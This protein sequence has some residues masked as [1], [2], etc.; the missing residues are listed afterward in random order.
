LDVLRV[1][2]TGA[3]GCLVGKAWAY[4]LGAGGGQGVSEMLATFKAELEVAMSLTG[5]TDLSKAGREL[6]VL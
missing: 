4:A 3:Q 1:L 2:A 6:L 5:C